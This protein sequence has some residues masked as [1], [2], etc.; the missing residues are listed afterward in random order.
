M[1]TSHVLLAPAGF[2]PSP[3]AQRHG[4]S[5][6]F[7][8]TLGEKPHVAASGFRGTKMTGLF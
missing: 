1:E 2:S 4:E 8:L 3:V 7:R 6:C 5:W